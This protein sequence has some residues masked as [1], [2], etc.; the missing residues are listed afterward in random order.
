[1]QIQLS[2]IQEGQP[3]AGICIPDV[4]LLPGP[5]RRGSGADSAVQTEDALDLRA[6][7][8]LLAAAFDREPDT[9]GNGSNISYFLRLLER[10]L[11]TPYFCTSP[12]VTLYRGGFR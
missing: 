2:G 7:S 1:M 3:A 8:F 6:G 10:D 4:G 12:S 5:P 11:M 9:D